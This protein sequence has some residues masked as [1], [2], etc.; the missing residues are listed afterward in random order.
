[1]FS[2]D[3]CFLSFVELGKRL[4]SALAQLIGVHDRLPAIGAFWGVPFPLTADDVPVV[5]A[6][7]GLLMI[8]LEG[9]KCQRM[10]QLIHE[11]APQ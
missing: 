10:N 5:F 6:H 4:Q 1:M 11:G 2:R 9:E 3:E 7:V 8:F